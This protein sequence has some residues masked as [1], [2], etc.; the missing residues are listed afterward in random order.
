MLKYEELRMNL[1]NRKVKFD[2]DVSPDELMFGDTINS[3]PDHVDAIDIPTHIIRLYQALHGYSSWRDTHTVTFVG[4]AHGRFESDHIFECTWPR[5]RYMPFSE[6][7]SPND[8][9]Y[10]VNRY[11]DAIPTIQGEELFLNVFNVTEGELYDVGDLID[12]I[13]QDILGYPLSEWGSWLNWGDDKMVCSVVARASQM[14]W[15]N[16]ELKY[17]TRCRRPGGDIHVER[18]PPALFP[19]HDTYLHL[20]KLIVNTA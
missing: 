3:S 17:V 4:D 5:A 9:T 10:N 6:W 18:T 14:N 12:F 15:H 11:A 7:Y 8:H 20:G 1:L 16:E 2:I 19:D 13:I